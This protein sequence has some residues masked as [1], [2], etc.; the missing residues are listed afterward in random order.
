MLIDLMLSLIICLA[1]MLLVC[2]VRRLV[3]RPVRPGKHILITVRLCV[4]GEAPEL[5]QTAKSL[6]WLRDSGTLPARIEL[7]DCG[8][9]PETQYI[10]AALAKE[11]D[12]IIRRNADG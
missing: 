12:L 5:E 8:I 6:L 11:H 1:L 3:F 2:F 4:S 7:E 10:A 9:G